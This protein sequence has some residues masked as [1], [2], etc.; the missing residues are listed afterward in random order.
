MSPIAI[1]LT[2]VPVKN[3]CKLLKT[4]EFPEQSDLEIKDYWKTKKE[5]VCFFI[6]NKLVVFCTQFCQNKHNYS[7]AY[8]IV[9]CISILDFSFVCVCVC[10][11]FTFV[12][13]CPTL[14]HYV[15]LLDIYGHFFP[16]IVLSLGFINTNQ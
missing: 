5:D 1:P 14:L 3:T 16:K 9:A 4:H 10:V 7:K 13:E 15:T 11:F 12:N 6:Q 2:T 8:H